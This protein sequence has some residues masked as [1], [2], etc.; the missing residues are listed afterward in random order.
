MN[1]LDSPLEAL[2]FIP[3]NLGPLFSAAIINLWTWLAVFTAAFSFWRLRLSSPKSHISLSPPK[4]NPPPNTTTSFLFEEREN[5]EQ[6]HDDEQEQQQEGEGDGVVLTRGNS[7]KF[8]TS[9]YKEREHDDGDDD[10]HHD[11][12][13]NVHDHDDHDDDDVMDGGDEVEGDQCVMIKKWGS[14][15]FTVDFGWYNYQNRNVIDGSVVRLWEEER[16][17]SSPRSC[18]RSIRVTLRR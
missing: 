4:P 11:D 3:L 6:H 12:D 1:G 5:V 15:E 9:Y 14:S 2:A 13:G 18:R 7:K 17:S 8:F 16:E 10:D